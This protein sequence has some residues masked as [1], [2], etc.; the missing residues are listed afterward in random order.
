MGLKVT[1]ITIPS[2]NFN[3]ASSLP[4]IYSLD[5]VQHKTES[6]LGEYE[7]LFIEYGFTKYTFPYTMQ[8]RYDRATANK[9][10]LA[11][12]LEN[13]YLKA[14]FLPE[15]GGRIWSLFDK[16]ANKELLYVNSMVRPGNLALRNAWFSGGIEYNVGVIS[17]SAYTC[18]KLHTAITSLD[19][20]TPV[21]RFYQHERIRNAVF[22][23]DFFLPS[24]SKVLLAR[25]RIVNPNLETTPMYWYTNIAMPEGEEYRNVMNAHSAYTYGYVKPGKKAIIHPDVPFDK[26]LVHAVTYN[27]DVTYPTN[28]ATAGDFFW[29]I[30]AGER[31]YTSYLNKDGYGF[32]QTSTSRQIGRKLFVW[33]L[34]EGSRKWQEYLTSDGRKDGYVEIQ[35]GLT[36]TQYETMPMPPKT[37]WEWV[38]CYGAIQG[39]AEKVHGDWDGAINEISCRLNE[40][41]TEEYLEKLLLDTREM[42]TSPAKEMVL[43]GDPWGTLENIRRE[44]AGKPPICS[45]LDFGKLT[46]EQAPFYKLLSDNSFDLDCDLLPPKAWM[47]QPEWTKIIENS[48]DCYLKYLHLSAIYL[49]YDELEKAE[50]A[51]VKALEYG[52]MPTALFVLAQVKIQQ[53]KTYEACDYLIEAC[54]LL[55][56]DLTLA[57]ESLRTLVDA[58]RYMDVISVYKN[59]DVSISNDGRI[60]MYYCYGLLGIGKVDEAF[61]R[62]N[63]D[64]GIVVSDIREVETTITE[65][66]IDIM[67][68]FAKRENKPFDPIEVEVPKKFDFRMF[69][70]KK[71]K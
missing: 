26:K 14:I 32:F 53:E 38:E 39:D 61:E 54:A 25:M 37:T 28:I 11:I 16:K 2:A 33:G 30:P 52:K 55:N 15:L 45:H 31:K 4:T 36:H 24:G 67:E 19:D 60:L 12:E 57:R 40:I 35:A 64:G 6:C 27:T 56:N 8:D 49:S 29:K 63:K 69:V 51:S 41:V 68:A 7:G 70:P 62:L 3:G 5:N 42:A 9:E 50:K 48:K 59:L 47:R 71:K 66:Y 21:L 43:Y 20:G 23:M 10:Y 58:K 17:H 65:L 13:E 46:E 34:G 1:K 18:D 22:Q 44:K